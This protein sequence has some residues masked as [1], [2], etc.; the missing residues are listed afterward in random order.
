MKNK[1]IKK[2]LSITLTILIVLSISGLSLAYYLARIQGS[3]KEL[4]S[5]SGSLSVNYNDE[6]EIQADNLLPGW[7]TEKT[8]TVTNNGEGEVKYNL[9]WSCI[10][11]ELER[12][13]DLT[14]TITENNN[15]IKT[16]TFP[17]EAEEKTIIEQTINKGE[18]KTYTVK[19]EYARSN[20]DQSIDMGKIFKGIIDVQAEGTEQKNS[21]PT[22]TYTVEIEPEEEVE[23]NTKQI[24]NGENAT[25]TYTGTLRNP[26]ITCTNNQSGK[27]E[28][29]IITINKVTNNTTCSISSKHTVQI[30]VENGTTTETNK[31]VNTGEETTFKTTPNT[32]YS[33]PTVTCTNN[34]KGTIQNNTVTITNIT[35]DTTCTVTYKPIT[36]TITYNLGGGSVTGNPS[37]YTIETNT[38][39]LKNPTKTGYTFTGWTGSNGSTPQ[40]TVTIPKGS[41]GNK[42]YTAN[43]KANTYQIKYNSN[44]GV[45]TMSNSTHTYGESKAL[46][47][48]TFTKTGYTFQGWSTSSTSNTVKYTNGQNV[49]NLTST[50]GEVINLY[51]VWKINTY[52]VKVTVTNGTISGSTSKTVNYNTNATFTVN[53]TD[54]YSNPTITCTNNQKGTIQNNTVTVSKITNDTTCTVTYKPTTYTITY[55]LGGG[56][57]TGNPATYTIE[58]NTIT[59]KNP[60]KTGYT[61]TGWTGSNGSTAQ[62]TVTIP[63]GSIGNKTYTANYKINTYKVNVTVLNGTITGS[64]SKTVNY[65]TNATFTVNPS[66]GY[67][68]PTVSCTNGQKGSINGNTLTVSNVTNNTTCT[69]TYIKTTGIATEVIIAKT[70]A[71]NTEGLIK[72]DQP[73]TGQTEAQTEYRYSGSNDVVKNYVNFNNETWRIIGVFPTD[74]G[75]GKIENRIKIIREESIGDY[76]WDTSVSTI[77]YGYGINQWGSSGSYNGADLMKLLNPGYESESVNNSLYWNRRSGTCYNDFINETTTCDF[78]STGLTENAK[79]M[80]DNAKW[81]TSAS[82]SDITASES[83]AEERSSTTTQFTTDTGIT[84]T[85]TTNWTGKVG[86]MYPSD[87]GY[88]SSGC[89]NDEQTFYDYY[90]E[91]CR[92]TNWLYNSDNQW[93]LSPS[94]EDRIYVRYVISYGNVFEYDAGYPRGARPVIYLSSSVKITGGNGTLSSPYELEI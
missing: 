78:S 27:I 86:L 34:Q 43:Y 49:T 26:K 72:I 89:R 94:A 13:Q 7:T 93:L 5:T 83:Y 12:T 74:D 64:T 53:P 66:S 79:E 38:I 28:G 30:K 41:T 71:N 44:G 73:A 59:L 57:V 37:T 35:N 47:T 6:K 32:G 90:N 8:L 20:E 69:V 42:S 63:K 16:G 82:N 60:T 51:A 36:Y 76:S 88:A 18:T 84:V 80:I 81:Y 9:Y 62:T 21:C 87:Y 29:K 56:S 91:T 23:E 52:T 14:Y 67:G 10:E 15:E 65:N 75:T 70:T 58:T 3:G 11:N 92:S 68:N 22:K 2:I 61:F 55:N 48:N 17:T 33:N 19:I 4:T 31:E 24:N 1:N 39:T 50:N 85:R 45:G 40:T 46:S 77:N 25:F 54:G